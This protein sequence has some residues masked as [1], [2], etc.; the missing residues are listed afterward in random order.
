L[1]VL[2]ATGVLAAWLSSVFLTV[3]GEETFFEAAAMLVTFVLFGHWMEM[4]SRKGTSDSLR[5]LFDIVPPSATVIRDGQEIELPTAEIVVGDLIRLKPGDKVPVDGVV[6]SGSSSIDESLVTGESIPV[7]KDVG[8]SLVGGS[9]NQSGTLTFEATKIGADTALGQIID[10][11]ERAQ[12]SK[13][14][15]QRLADR[16]AGAAQSAEKR[17]TEPDSTRE[18]RHAQLTRRLDIPA[19]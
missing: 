4:K 15:G 5:A 14:P 1:A 11:V 6:K 7:A 17:S 8:D 2:V 9:V 19:A 12:N 10:L 3:I 13:A 18:S 16:A